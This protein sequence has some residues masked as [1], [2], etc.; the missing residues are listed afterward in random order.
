MKMDA[1]S[2]KDRERDRRTWWIKFLGTAYRQFHEDRVRER[3]KDR[4]RDREILRMYG[5]H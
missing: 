5:F 4:E 2:L 1:E 3:E